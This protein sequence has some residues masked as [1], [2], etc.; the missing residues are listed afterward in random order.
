LLTGNLNSSIVLPANQCV[1]PSS[2]NGPVAV[3]IT[4][5]SAPLSGDILQRQKQNNTITAG[6]N[7]FFADEIVDPIGK[8]VLSGSQ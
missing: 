3:F 1:V 6:P 2:V 8:L 5:T 7:L 4:N